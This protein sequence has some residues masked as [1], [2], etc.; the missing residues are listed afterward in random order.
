M[1]VAGFIFAIFSTQ[2]ARAYRMPIPAMYPALEVGDHF[3][4]SLTVGELKRGQIVA[5]QFPPDPTKS[6][7]QR[8][9]GL[10]GDSIEIRR[11]ELILN[12]TP[13]N[14]EPLSDSCMYDTCTMWQETIDGSSYRTA[15][16]EGNSFPESQAFGPVTVPDGQLFVL[17]DNRDN[18][19]DS[20]Y[21]GFL[22]VEFVQ[23][24]PQFIYWSSEEGEIRWNR[25]GKIVK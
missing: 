9:V 25:I 5:F 19:L 15:I 20:R 8:I 2:F 3:M 6:F 11:G 10:S 4:C 24:K 7:V 16:I 14:R 12:G 13:V 18:S 21:W 1:Y 23:A 17:G 22:P